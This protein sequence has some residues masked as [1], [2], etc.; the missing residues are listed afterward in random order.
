MIKYNIRNG[1]SPNGRKP[2]SDKKSAGFSLYGAIE[3][4]EHF[5]RVG[6]GKPCAECRGNNGLERIA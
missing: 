4:A 6:E 5:T 2:V 3:N 1:T